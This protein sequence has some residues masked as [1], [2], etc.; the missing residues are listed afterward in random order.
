MH[1][2]PTPPALVRVL[3]A[4]LAVALGCAGTEGVANPASQATETDATAG[5]T[6]GTE[7]VTAETRLERVRQVAAAPTPADLPELISALDDPDFRVRRDAAGA[8]ARLGL[9]AREAV[10]AL[11]DA[12][13]DEFAFVR[14]RAAWAL[15]RIGDDAALDALRAWA[16]TID[17]DELDHAMDAL[18][19][20]G[21]AESVDL[22]ADWMTWDDPWIRRSAARALVRI[23]PPSAPAAR[24]M[25]DHPDEAVACAAIRVLGYVGD[26]AVD[27]E[28]LDVADGD[29]SVRALC[30][31]GS[32]ARFGDPSAVDTLTRVARSNDADA[33]EVA[34]DSLAI[35]GSV[36]ALNRLIDLLPVF[37][38]DDRPGNAAERA[39]I[40]IGDEARAAIAVRVA[41]LDGSSPALQARVLAVIGDP[42]DLRALR[43][44]LTST[45]S[46]R[47]RRALEDAIVAIEA[48]APEHP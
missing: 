15:T 3:A 41:D 17:P 11:T 9:E 48:R 44:A 18:G 43:Q 26:P 29:R 47:D 46:E 4:A 14:Q 6:D 31:L 38:R 21:D 25:L 39:L 30:S 19:T 28:A 23:G 12:L 1:R 33:A 24:A 27:R 20:L 40:A 42:R 22:I 7:S 8:I 34:V 35:A 32:L 2:L 16:Q 45:N 13:D 36:S 5:E 10:P 37:E